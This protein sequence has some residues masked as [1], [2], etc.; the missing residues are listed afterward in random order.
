MPKVN[1]KRERK[2]SL[3]KKSSSSSLPPSKKTKGSTS[4]SNS[5]TNSNT[6]NTNNSSD[7]I[8][9]FGNIYR[10]SK[11]KR[12]YYESCHNIPIPFSI[13]V[14]SKR[15]QSTD[16]TTTTATTTTISKNNTTTTPTINVTIGDV[17][18]VQVD[19]QNTASPLKKFLHGNK[20]QIWYP[21]TVPWAT[22]EVLA[23]YKKHDNSNNNK[24]YQQQQ[25]HQQCYFIVRYFNRTNET[26]LKEIEKIHDNQ[27]QPYYNNNNNNNN[28]DDSIKY[29]IEDLKHIEEVYETDFVS[30]ILPLSILG[31]AYVILPGGLNIINDMTSFHHRQDHDHHEGDELN[32]RMIENNNGVIYIRQYSKTCLLLNTKREYSLISQYTGKCHFD[33]ELD[34]FITQYIQKKIKDIRGCTGVD[35]FWLF[36][37]CRGI[38]CFLNHHKRGRVNNNLIECCLKFAFERAKV[39]QEDI[40]S[41]DDESNFGSEE[42][43]R[44]KTNEDSDSDEEIV[45]DDIHVEFDLNEDDNG[46]IYES[47]EKTITDGIMHPTP[48]S[49]GSFSDNKGW[50]YKLPFHV[51]VAALKAFYSEINIKVPFDSYMEPYNNNRNDENSEWKISIGDTVAIHVE[52]SKKNSRA[53]STTFPF[54][55]SWWPGEI[56]AIYSNIDCRDEALELREK[57][58]DA[59]KQIHEKKTDQFHIEIRW[60]YRKSNIPGTAKLKMSTEAP[61]GMEEVFETDTVDEIDVSSLLGSISLFSDPREKRNNITLRSGIPIVNFFC[62]QLWS[63]QR[64]SLMPIGASDKRI[65]RAMLYSKYMGRDSATRSAHGNLKLGNS[66]KV[67]EQEQ[68]YGW[69]QR[70]HDTFSKLTLAESS[71][72]GNKNEHHIIGR[73]REREQ[74]SQ[75]LKSAIQAANG[76]DIINVMNSNMFVLFIGG[77]PG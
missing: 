38:Q 34:T 72:I 7:S 66:N 76:R 64:K 12:T 42:I 68:N 25:K 50:V 26:S 49:Q 21:F 13:Y 54:E 44:N 20:N 32:Q 23:I 67:N 19:S 10:D 5:H 40:H 29:S 3:S 2:N 75:F 11:A 27:V 37:Y 65:E 56:V 52:E 69:K 46:K 1:K 16:I 77:A 62:H 15:K 17:L 51:D 48:C 55:V 41:D 43:A 57:T 9:T 63:V 59:N 74:I 53:I 47:P 61:N 35:L 31:K 24:H 36:R 33:N 6:N 58:I 30:E 14:P 60:F 8:E 70:F 39:R 73:E 4:H 28:N 71:V 18:I 45:H 22:C